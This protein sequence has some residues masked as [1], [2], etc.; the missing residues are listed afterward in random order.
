MRALPFKLNQ[1]D[2]QHVPEQTHKATN[3][4]AYEASLRER[5]SLAVW[6]SDEEIDA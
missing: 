3:W 6:F 2:R 4:P 1:H 5:G